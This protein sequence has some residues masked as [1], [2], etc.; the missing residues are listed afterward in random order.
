[1]NRQVV[2]TG[3]GIVSP[4]GIGKEEFRK[5]L[6]EGKSGVSPITLFDASALPT[7]IAAEVKGFNPLEMLSGMEILTFTNDR[8]TLLAHSACR[9]AL[10]DGGID[11]K[12]MGKTRCGVVLGSGIH[13][14]ISERDPVMTWGLDEGEQRG[15]Q[16]W[17]E[18]RSRWIKNILK[19]DDHS[20]NPATR[21]RAA[22]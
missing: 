3:L 12:E 4:I 19:G 7:R 21:H 16:N 2:I 5:N 9:L 11:S 8:R 6:S 14:M 17:D 22:T 13:P 10:M 1:M 18:F 15:R 20:P